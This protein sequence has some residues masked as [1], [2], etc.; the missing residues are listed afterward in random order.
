M[1]LSER[2]NEKTGCGHIWGTNYSK[3][4]ITIVTYFGYILVKLNDAFTIGKLNTLRPWL[5]MTIPQPLL[6][7]SKLLDITSNGITLI[8]WRKAKQTTIAKS[9]T[10]FIQDLEPAFN[11]NDVGREK[12]RPYYST[13]VFTVYCL[14]F[15]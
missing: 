14:V 11:V 10:L 12:L 5:K 13:L 3:T 6:T 1:L 7:T 4:G 15:A 9:E 8:F 2:N